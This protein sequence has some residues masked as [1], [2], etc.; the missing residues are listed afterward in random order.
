MKHQ[1][2]GSN[3]GSRKPVDRNTEQT[4]SG[5]LPADNQE[6]SWLSW[7][8]SRCDSIQLFSIR[9][10][11]APVPLNFIGLS[12]MWSELSQVVVEECKPNQLPC[13]QLVVYLIEFVTEVIKQSCQWLTRVL[14]A[15]LCF[16]QPE[17]FCQRLDRR[18]QQPGDK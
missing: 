1:K 11:T 5:E 6:L 15:A 17:V 13:L 10:I 4:A 7:S 9:F 8:F 3:E 2:C 12:P 14:A 18:S 16:S